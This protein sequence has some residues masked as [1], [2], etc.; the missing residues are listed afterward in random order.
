MRAEMK[1]LIDAMADRGL[2]AVCVDDAALAEL[3]TAPLTH[4]FGKHDVVTRDGH[5]F[6]HRDGRDYPIGR[7]VVGDSS[8]YALIAS[9]IIADYLGIDGDVIE[10]FLAE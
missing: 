6:L 3:A 2:L 7:E 9:V 10:R 1:D 4:R 8:L 5:M